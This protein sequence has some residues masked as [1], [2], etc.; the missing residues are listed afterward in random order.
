M[1]KETIELITNLT[2]IAKIPQRCKLSISS[3][4]YDKM[5]TYGGVIHHFLAGSNSE[6]ASQFV[7]NCV[8]TSLKYSSPLIRNHL[9]DCSTGI[10]NLIEIYDS[11]GTHHVQ[12][13]LLRCCMS[14]ID[15]LRHPTS[16]ENLP[17]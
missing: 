7:Y 4:T 6:E 9:L 3:Y 13:T 11:E 15:E 10:K 2:Y 12:V 14:K 17:E 5:D 1:D 16:S 8:V